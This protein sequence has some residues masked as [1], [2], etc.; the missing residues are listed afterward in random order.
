[1]AK[2][3]AEIYGA[4]TTGLTI[5]RAVNRLSFK[6]TAAGAGL[7]GAAAAVLTVIEKLR[8]LFGH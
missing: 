7:I 1:M 8:A 5:L 6:L 3:L 4:W 2:Q